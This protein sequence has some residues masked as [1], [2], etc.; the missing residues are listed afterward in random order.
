MDLSLQHGE[1]INIIL[2]DKTVIKIMYTDDDL[3]IST[4]VSD[5]FGRLG[6]VYRL[7]QFGE[8]RK[9]CSNENKNF[10]SVGDRHLVC[11][12]CGKAFILLQEEQ[13]FMVKTFGDE[14]RE[15]TRCS[16][17]RELRRKRKRNHVKNYAEIK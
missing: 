2:D 9:T 15:P 5:I 7:S 12:G 14:Y 13:E 17:C 11:S 1:L 4:N 16:E 6:E 10:K 3:I 8:S